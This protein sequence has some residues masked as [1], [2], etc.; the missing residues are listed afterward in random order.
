MDKKT[1]NPN[2]VIDL[3]LQQH[4]NPINF[5]KIVAIFRIQNY[6]YQNFIKIDKPV[7][8]TFISKFSNSNRVIDIG[9]GFKCRR[10][11]QLMK[12]KYYLGLDIDS[13]IQYDKFIPL[14]LNYNWNEQLKLLN[15][16]IQW[17]SFDNILI[18]NSIQNIFNNEKECIDN[19]NKL[20]RKGCIM[21]I[22]FL[23]WDLLKLL[24][25]SY[26]TRHKFC[27]NYWRKKD[28]ILLFK[29]SFKC[30]RRTYL[31]L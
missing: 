10:N 9:C 6:Y 17:H 13:K 24:K 21:I 3:I 18:I 30:T 20:A 15:N 2:K 11:S 16:D 1:A 26:K 5:N 4:K 29:C 22:K 28:K 8:D 12:S 7:K 27:K 23:D 31:F 19:I 14:N 25:R